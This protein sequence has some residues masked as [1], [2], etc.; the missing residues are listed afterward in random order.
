MKLKIPTVIARDADD[1]AHLGWL[2]RAADEA[3]TGVGVDVTGMEPDQF[4]RMLRR[5]WSVSQ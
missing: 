2:R 3:D 5:Y 4:I 1:A